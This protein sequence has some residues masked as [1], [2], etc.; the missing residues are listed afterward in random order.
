MRSASACQSTSSANASAQSRVRPRRRS[1]SER[2]SCTRNVSSALLSR[3]LASSARMDHLVPVP[4]VRVACMGLKVAGR[5]RR[6]ITSSTSHPGDM[7]SAADQAA[8]PEQGSCVQPTPEG[9]AVGVGMSHELP[10]RGPSVRARREGERRRLVHTSEVRRAWPEFAQQAAPRLGFQANPVNRAFPAPA[11][12]RSRER[13]RTGDGAY[14]D[15]TD[16]LR[17]AKPALSQLS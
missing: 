5:G 13:A 3:S 12:L 14:R 15:R 8:H 1:C 4:A 16:D 6:N 9:E 7:K 10:R 11:L 17:L 2:H